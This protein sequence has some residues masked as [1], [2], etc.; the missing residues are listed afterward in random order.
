MERIKKQRVII[1]ITAFVFVLTVTGL[2]VWIAAERKKY[3]EERNIP[4][5][6]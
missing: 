1:W 6:K 4:A 2:S 5:K 3:Q